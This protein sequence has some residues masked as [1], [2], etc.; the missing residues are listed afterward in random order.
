MNTRL[1]ASSPISLEA[2]PLEL[3]A[4][5]I[6]RSGAISTIEAAGRIGQ[7]VSVAGMRMTSHRHK[8]SQGQWMMFLTLEDLEGMLDAVLLPD[9]LNK[10][11]FEISG[12]GP[13]LVTG[14][15]ELDP[16]RGEPTLRAEKIERLT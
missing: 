6:K 13:L 8:N 2:H 4:E 9:V 10:Y 7:R 12:P 15:I 16:G 14:T 11:R 5:A 1:K 3:H